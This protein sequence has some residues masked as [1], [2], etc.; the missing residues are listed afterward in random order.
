MKLK[1]ELK[2]IARINELEAA[3]RGLLF[4]VNDVDIGK[5]P[6]PVYEGIALLK[7]VVKKNAS[8]YD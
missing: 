4:K 6:L 2:Y 5:L 8:I 7:S 3:I 1:E